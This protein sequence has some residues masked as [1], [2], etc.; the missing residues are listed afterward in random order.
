MAQ[1]LQAEGVAIVRTSPL[2]CALARRR[3][4][5][6][7]R[8]VPRSSSTTG[9]SSST[10]AS[11][12]RA[13]SR[14][15]RPPSSP[16]GAPTRRSRPPGGESLRAVTRARSRRS[17]P[18]CSPGPKVIAVSH[19]SPIK[20]A[21][22]W[23]L[24]ASEVLGW[25]M[26]LDLAS[27]TQDRRDATRRRASSATTTSHTFTELAERTPR[28]GRQDQA[29]VT[30]IDGRRGGRLCVPVASITKRPSPGPSATGMPSA[31]SN[32]WSS[33]GARP[34]VVR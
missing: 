6:P 31:S 18:S 32:A 17:A 24:G 11:G 28:R 7:P 22:T 16:A 29:D 2:R 13:A 9:S 14:T 10:T 23:A 20:A 25:R 4:R 30:G 34:P 33:S 8:P 1:R 15:C 21:V 5:S 12:I 19:V 27:I 26:F 3:P